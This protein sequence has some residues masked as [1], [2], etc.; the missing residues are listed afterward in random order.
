[1]SGYMHPLNRASDSIP[2]EMLSV[3][4]EIPHTAIA[5]LLE[6]IKEN[7]VFVSEN[8]ENITPSVFAYVKKNTNELMR[9]HSSLNTMKPLKLRIKVVAE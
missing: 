1:M 3:T 6:L 5:A 9:I 8:K 7:E 4:K 2:N